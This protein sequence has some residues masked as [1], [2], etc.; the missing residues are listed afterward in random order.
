MLWLRS[1]DTTTSIFMQKN[2]QKGKKI[3]KKVLTM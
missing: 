3:C 1:A 2:L